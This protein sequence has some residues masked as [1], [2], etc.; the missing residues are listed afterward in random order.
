MIVGDVDLTPQEHI[1]DVIGMHDLA[2][3]CNAIHF[4]LMPTME[5]YRGSRYFNQLRARFGENDMWEHIDYEDLQTPG[6]S[7]R[8]IKGSK[9][10]D[11]T[12][13]RAYEKEMLHRKE[14]QQTPSDLQSIE[15][16]MMD[17][18]GVYEERRDELKYGRL[19]Y[20][21]ENPKVELANIEEALKIAN[22]YFRPLPF[23]VPSKKRKRSK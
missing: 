21:S 19:T 1:T 11:P 15:D 5:P 10:M 20:P 2:R 23:E 8:S 6:G 3:R 22:D 13:A 7:Y 18:F 9:I 4:V 14:L 12:T 16:A 17:V